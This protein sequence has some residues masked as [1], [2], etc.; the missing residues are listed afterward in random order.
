MK[1]NLITLLFLL[2]IYVGRQILENNILSNTPLIEKIILWGLVI[3]LPMNLLRAWIE[4]GFMNGALRQF[5]EYMLNALALTP[6]A[7]AYCGIVAL[8][9][10]HRSG[11]LNW[12]AAVGR[13]A[14]S[15]YLFQ[16]IIS[17]FVFYG[18]GLGFAMS[19]GYTS[20][21]I[22]VLTLYIWQILF[23]TI[24]LR[25]FRFGPVEWIW[26]QLTYGRLI[27]LRKTVK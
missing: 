19:F 21:I 16:S 23:S 2:G 4:F 24:W 8:I 11:W 20:V 5:L 18:V 1:I 15:N 9:V 14:L 22:F 7:L 6:M 12:F 25:Y 13:T 17:I 10:T 27:K 26:R 3:G